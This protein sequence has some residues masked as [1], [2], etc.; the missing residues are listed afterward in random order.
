MDKSTQAVLWFAACLV[1]VFGLG[2][3]FAAL[4]LVPEPFYVIMLLFFG[5]FAAICTGMTS[6]YLIN[7]KSK[8]DE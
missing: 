4:L 2:A 5:V 6:D 3:A 7:S 8:P 1:S